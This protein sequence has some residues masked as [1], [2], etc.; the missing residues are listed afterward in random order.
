MPVEKRSKS[1]IS[2]RA[3]IEFESCLN[4]TKK[5]N[6]NGSFYADKLGKN[7][8]VENIHNKSMENRKSMLQF[9]HER[10]NLHQGE[11]N[12]IYSYTLSSEAYF[13]NIFIR[14]SSILQVI[15]VISIL[16]LRRSYSFN[17]SFWIEV[18]SSFA[19]E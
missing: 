2:N 15:R 4:W 17:C 14:M 12:W 8:K 19:F 16:L 6:K 7:L 18:W 13:I 5:R 10:A 1:K 11:E 3:R 9:I